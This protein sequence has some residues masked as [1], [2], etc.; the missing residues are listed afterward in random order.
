[1]IINGISDEPRSKFILLVL[2]AFVV[3]GQLIIHFLAH[4]KSRPKD[5]STMG[6][7]DESEFELALYFAKIVSFT[8]SVILMIVAIQLVQKSIGSPLALGEYFLPISVGLIVLIMMIYA[9][10]LAKKR[11]T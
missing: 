3:F 11:K 1:M 9:L 6:F 4:R 2:I 10:Q 8:V 5:V 7:R